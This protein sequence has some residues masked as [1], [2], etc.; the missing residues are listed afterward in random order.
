[1]FSHISNK[2]KWHIKCLLSWERL[3][4]TNMHT[5]QGFTETD[6][7]GGKGNGYISPSSEHFKYQN[8]ENVCIL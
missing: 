8:P 2:Y 4:R 5:G 1:M 7:A 3:K 6:I